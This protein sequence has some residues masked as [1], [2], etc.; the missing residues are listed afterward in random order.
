MKIICVGRNYAAHAAELCNPA[1]RE[2]VIFMKPDT[3]IPQR[4]NPF[5]IPAFSKDVHYEAELVFRVC[6]NGK[7]IAEKFAAGY[8]DAVTVGIDF[9]ARD[10]QGTLKE[11]GLPWELAKGFDGSAP[12]GEFI[13]LEELPPEKGIAFRL[14]RNGATVQKGNSSQMTFPVHHLVSFI[15]S[16]FTLKE[17]DLLFTGT[18]EGVGPV[19][20]DDLLEGYIGDR[21]LLKIAVK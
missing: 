15:S 5:I 1:P 6:R 18:P 20:R 17:G 19:K 12:V 21:K 2:P 9:T 11:K 16:Y 7:H 14:D 10:L 3:A 4:R 13:P 8:L